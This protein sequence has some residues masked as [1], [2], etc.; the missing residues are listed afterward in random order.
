MERMSRVDARTPGDDLRWI[1]ACFNQP[2]ARSRRWGEDALALLRHDAQI[3][4]AQQRRGKVRGERRDK[5][6]IETPRHQERHD[7]RRTR[8][9]KMDHIDAIEFRALEDLGPHPVRGQISAQAILADMNV[10]RGMSNERLD[11]RRGATRDVAILFGEEGYAHFVM[12][13]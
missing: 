3:L 11:R 12:R 13:D 5:R 7:G 6:H 2:I 10:T 4:P 1:D 8:G 9:D